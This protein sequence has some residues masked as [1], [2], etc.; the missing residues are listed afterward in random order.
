MKILLLQDWLR[1]GGTERQSVLLANAFAAAGHTVT[2]LTFRPGG[3]LAATVDP[4]VTR[5][6]LQPFDTRLDWFAPGL[7]RFIARRPPDVIL[8]LGRMANCY[9][10]NIVCATRDRWPRLAVIG[11][12]RT[13]KPLPRLFRLSLRHVRHIIA[14]SQAAKATLVRDHG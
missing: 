2:L 11:T 3:A 5:A 7:T 9:G 13:G 8:C 10:Q 6:A 4:A 1:S 14:N 12:M